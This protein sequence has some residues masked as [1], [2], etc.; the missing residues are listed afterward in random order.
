MKFIPLV[1]KK[2]VCRH[3]SHSTGETHYT[4]EQATQGDADIFRIELTRGAGA[5]MVG[6]EV[7]KADLVCAVIPLRSDDLTTAVSLAPPLPY[8]AVL[9]RT[10]SG[11][12]GWLLAAR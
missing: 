3:F 2:Q 8:L 10:F 5:R 6:Y 7:R 12:Q 4:P 9:L 1:E 11:D